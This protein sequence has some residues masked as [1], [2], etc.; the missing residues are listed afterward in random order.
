MY[1]CPLCRRANP[2]EAVF[3]HF[4]GIQLRAVPGGFDPR[5]YALLPHDFF[6]PSGRRCRTYDEF[7]QACQDEWAVAS[8]LLQR[9]VFAQFLAGVGRLDL[10]GSAQ[11]AVAQRD[12]DIALE[13]FLS[14]LPSTVQRAP[15]LEVAPH[16][17]VLGTLGAGEVRQVWVLVTNQGKGLLHGVITVS[18]GQAW[19][20]LAKPDAE[21]AASGNGVPQAAIKTPR[22]QRVVLQVDTRDLGAQAYHGRL[23]V[24]T[25]GGNQEVPVTLTVDVHGFPHAPF[26]GA[27]SPRELAERMVLRPKDAV[28]LFESGAVAR[29]FAD[30]GWTYPVDGAQA[31]G[32]AAVQQFFEGLHLSKAPAVQLAEAH[33]SFYCAS[34]EVVHG[35]LHL[36]T[37]DRKWIYAQAD[38]DVVWLR[39]LTPVVC[40]P[41][42]AV[43]SF[44]ADSSLLEPGQTYEA[45]IRLSANAGQR[46]TAR[47]RLE[48]L[49]PQDPLTRRLFR[50]F[51]FE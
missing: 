33:L 28:P 40:G 5:S 41:Q 44:E 32:M 51:A 20:R 42:K 2:E 34:P 12:P 31:P 4:D 25:N 3:C 35:Q 14:A 48:V 45:A 49:R 7:V 10:A 38:T 50:P 27:R 43:V 26:Q 9:G 17:L 24:I 16:R 8:N 46:L 18:E 23:T 1:V 15:R 21:G 13:A 6:F 47:V 30:N 36:V 19:L 37:N 29:W 11:A 22:E 39:L